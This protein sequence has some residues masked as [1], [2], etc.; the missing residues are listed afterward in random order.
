LYSANVSTVSILESCSG[1]FRLNN[2]GT[3]RLPRRLRD[4][5]VFSCSSSMGLIGDSTARS[6]GILCCLDDDV[7]NDAG[8]G[9]D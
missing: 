6:D 3:K 4:S 9:D 5:V 8:I 7:M 1:D 2:L